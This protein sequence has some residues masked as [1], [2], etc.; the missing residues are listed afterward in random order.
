[1]YKRLTNYVFL[2]FFGRIMAKLVELQASVDAVSAGVV[3]AVAKIDELKASQGGAA[4][5]AEL[6]DV[7]VKL[8]AAAAALAAA[9]A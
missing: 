4:S 3:V 9:V 8:D 6:E 5:E 2:L 1:V 7:K